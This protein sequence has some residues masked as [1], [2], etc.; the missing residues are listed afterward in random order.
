MEEIGSWRQALGEKMHM[1]RHYAVGVDGDGVG[2][3]F[4]AE[5]FEKP[6]GAGWV[7][8]YFFAVFGAEG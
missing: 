7:E 4:G 8:E 6:F 3:G 5:I 1:V 2:E